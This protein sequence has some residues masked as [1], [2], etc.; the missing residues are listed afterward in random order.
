M[1]RDHKLKLKAKE[2]RSYCATM[3]LFKAPQLDGL[4]KA[5]GMTA[6]TSKLTMYSTRR[7]L[8]PSRVGASLGGTIQFVGWACDVNLDWILIIKVK[9]SSDC[10]TFH[11]VRNVCTADRIRNVLVKYE[12]ST[13][14]WATN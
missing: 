14:K 2:T 9:L 8:H 5:L 1:K 4:F 12:D 13:W 6:E 11:L 7:S 10:M 3:T